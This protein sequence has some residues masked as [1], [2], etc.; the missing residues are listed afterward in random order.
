MPKP[1]KDRPE[2]SRE[3]EYK[4]VLEELQSQFRTFGEGLEDVRGHVERIEVDVLQIKEDVVILKVD[5][6]VLKVDV[7]QLKEDVGLLK[8][9]ISFVRKALPTVATKDDLIPLERR[10]S[11]LE[12]AR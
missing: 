11:A 6:G 5:V 3:R 12:S 2:F 9:Q 10:V 4:V 8:T 1:G 7:G